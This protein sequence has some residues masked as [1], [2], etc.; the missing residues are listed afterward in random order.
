MPHKTEDLFRNA[1]QIAEK[2]VR[3]VRAEQSAQLRD[4]ICAAVRALFDQDPTN[5]EPKRVP[6]HRKV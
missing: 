5:V 3:Y 4:M 2:R 6:P 1:T